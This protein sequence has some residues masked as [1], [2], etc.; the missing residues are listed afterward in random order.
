[1]AEQDTEIPVNDLEND[2]TDLLNKHGVN[3]TMTPTRFLARYLI[4]DIDNYKELEQE[5]QRD[6][7]RQQSGMGSETP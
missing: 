6:Y 2:L 3:N 1:M 4:R 5:A 7:V